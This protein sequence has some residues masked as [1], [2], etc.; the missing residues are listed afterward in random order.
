MFF[1]QEVMDEDLYNF[2]YVLSRYTGFGL[3]LN[4]A[5]ALFAEKAEKPALKDLMKSIQKDL[6]AGSKFS[7]ALAKHKDVFPSFIIEN[8]RVGEAS[9]QMAP[10]LNN[11]VFHMEQEIRVNKDIESAL[12]PQKIFLFLLAVAGI[13][14]LFLVIPKMGELLKSTEVELPWFTLMVVGFGELLSS[15]W[16]LFAILG[17]LA[18][19]GLHTYKQNY[20]EEWDA[21]MLKIPFFSDLNYSRLQYRFSLIFGL[22]LQSGI[23]TRRALEYTA[24]AVD[25]LVMKKTLQTAVRLMTQRGL[26]LLDAL[27]RAN[28]ETKIL[29][30][31]FQLMLSVGST[32]SLDEI[33]LSESKKYQDQMIRLSKQ[34]GDKVGLSVAI[35]G[36]V[37]MLLLFA[38]IELPIFSMIGNIDKLG[39]M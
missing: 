8:I 22:C 15:F 36:Y 32:G 13:I 27:M 7:D 2:L 9:S 18:V 5:V 24:N 29:H 3:R 31:D 35:P 4:D 23:D 10:I 21:L 19:V 25:N 12:V 39:G 33:M 38:A 30:H 34:I 16:W 28:D 1:R 37:I 14:I 26:S 17:V 20:P 6:T 11:L